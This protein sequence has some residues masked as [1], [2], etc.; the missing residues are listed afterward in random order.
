MISK[1][2]F[3]GLLILLIGL[4]SH[5]SPAMAG[6]LS[7][8]RKSMKSQG[9]RSVSAAP[10][11][12]QTVATL[13]TEMAQG[14]EV[15]GSVASDPVCR[16]V[17]RDFAGLVGRVMDAY[18]VG[19]SDRWFRELRAYNTLLLCLNKEGLLRID[20]VLKKSLE[21][22]WTEAASAHS[23]AVKKAIQA[24][25]NLQ[26]LLIDMIPFE[27]QV[28][29]LLKEKEDLVPVIFDD[30]SLEG[31][32]TYDL[33][34]GTYDFY[35]LDSHQRESLSAEERG[36][37]SVEETRQRMNDRKEALR[38]LIAKVTAYENWGVGCQMGMILNEGMCCL[39]VQCQENGRGRLFQ[40]A[41]VT[42]AYRNERGVSGEQ[43]AAMCC[44]RQERSGWLHGGRKRRGSKGKGP[45]DRQ[46]SFDSF[47]K[48]ADESCE[49]RFDAVGILE[50]RMA[51][52]NWLDEVLDCQAKYRRPTDPLSDNPVLHPRPP[53][54]AMD[55][56]CLA[57]AGTDA[58]LLEEEKPKQ[59]AEKKLREPTKEEKA[60]LDKQKT[61]AKADLEGK[62][63]DFRQAYENKSGKISDA[64]WDKK[65]KEFINRDPKVKVTDGNIKELFDNPTGSEQ[66]AT[67]TLEDGSKVIVVDK[68]QASGFEG[69][70]PN[71]EIMAHEMIHAGFGNGLSHDDITRLGKSGRPNPEGGT[72]DCEDPTG[73]LARFKGLFDC[74]QKA[75]G[76]A[77]IPT[78]PVQD[79]LNA[80]KDRPLNVDPRV[81]NPGPEG[82][83]ESRDCSSISMANVGRNRDCR[84]VDCPEGSLPAKNA[85]GICV[86]G[87]G[88]LSFGT[89]RFFNPCARMDCGEG[90]GHPRLNEKNICVCDQGPG[91]LQGPGFSGPGRKGPGI[92]GGVGGGVN[93]VE[94]P[95]TGP[96]VDGGLGG[97]GGIDPE[98]DG[99][100]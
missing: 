65:W 75:F 18:V 43:I 20:R 91:G 71:V 4:G 100:R 55:R 51:R 85:H 98:E 94:G 46:G 92:D 31:V 53:K 70:V 82:T 37:A 14:F 79:R 64:D 24:S 56:N 21:P 76:Q 60:K 5:V 52:G 22:L 48:G 89:D 7:A 12:S 62:K 69:A 11:I 15:A 26:L 68:W 42:D 81:V 17:D 66:A 93:P 49:D 30:Y 33:L 63:A 78:S 39:G 50:E 77:G 67:A 27:S 35:L 38:D 57:G 61:D 36:R 19:D 13:R 87:A 28:L 88:V 32:W 34:D 9:A 40:T 54:G 96:G 45:S 90:G 8:I 74:T 2:V 97:G 1:R 23:E 83:L 16:S 25:L 47:H 10:L 72:S 41:D 58:Q 44:S 86:C 84:D 73:Q 80:R 95:P 59:D 29:S 3:L 6:W 99:G